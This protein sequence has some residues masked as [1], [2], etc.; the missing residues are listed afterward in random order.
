MISLKCGLVDLLTG[1]QT[2]DTATVTNRMAPLTKTPT[3]PFEFLNADNLHR[4]RLIK[5]CRVDVRAG[6]LIS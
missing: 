3:P 2:R 5:G 4:P 6:C 1:T